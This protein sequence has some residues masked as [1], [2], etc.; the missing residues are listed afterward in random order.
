VDRFRF[1]PR[2][3]STLF[4]TR[5][6]TLGFLGFLWF[7]G[8]CAA[9]LRR[10]GGASFRCRCGAWFRG[11]RRA[12]SRL[13]LGRRVLRG[14]TPRRRVRP[15]GDNLFKPAAARTTGEQRTQNP[16]DKNAQHDGGFPQDAALPLL[17][18]ERSH[19]IEQRQ[20]TQA[21]H[22]MLSPIHV[23]KDEQRQPP[24]RAFM[25][26]QIRRERLAHSI[27]AAPIIFRASGSYTYLTSPNEGISSSLFA[28]MQ[29]RPAFPLRA[30][31]KR[32]PLPFPYISGSL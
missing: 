7:C 22:L 32:A 6:L 4:F 28:P 12:A 21:R 23:S 19:E 25:L 2:S 17:E 16:Y 26:F 5:A 30:G 11:E 31:R 1:A 24:L 27:N 13:V 18:R 20:V 14:F 15:I 3:D 29:A 9:W 10:R 8:G